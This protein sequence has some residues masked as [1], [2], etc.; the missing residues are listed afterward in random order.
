[1]RAIGNRADSRT[2]VLALLLTVIMVFSVIA[3]APGMVVAESDEHNLLEDG[4]DEADEIYVD[5]DGNAVLIYSDEDADDDDLDEVELG[6]HVAEGIMY[7]FAADSHDVD[8]ADEFENVEMHASALLRGDIFEA[9]GSL[10]LDQPDE[11]GELDVD[12]HGEVSDETNELSAEAYA[13]F[14]D[15]TGTSAAIGQVQ[16]SGDVTIA[17]DSFAMQADGTFASG[18][19]PSADT[20][21]IDVSIEESDGTYS[22]EVTQ[23]EYLSWFEAEQ[24]ETEQA[25]RDTL[26]QEF[27]MIAQE[28]GGE[29]H[30]TIDHYHFEERSDRYWLELEYSVEMSG[31]DDGLA[32]LIAEGLMQDPDIDVDE[33]QAIAIGEAVTEI[34]IDRFDIAFVDDGATVEFDIDVQIDGFDELVFAA[35][36]VFEDEFDE[37]D[38]EFE[39]VEDV[40]EMY[41]A[42]AAADMRTHITWDVSIEAGDDGIGEPL[43]A[44]STNDP[45]IVVDAEFGYEVEN[46]Q[47]YVAELNDRG[48]D[49]AEYNFA[50]TFEMYDVDDQIH[51]EGAITVEQEDLVDAAMDSLTTAMSEEADDPAAAEFVD[52]LEQTNLEVAKIDLALDDEEITIE[53]GAQVDD[54]EEFFRNADVVPDEFVMDEPGGDLYVHLTNV[55]EE[56]DAFDADDLESYAFVGEDTEIHA[57]GEWDEEFPEFDVQSAADYLDVE[58]SEGGDDETSPD[59]DTIPGFGPIAALIAV[60]GALVARTYGR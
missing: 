44:Q 51:A 5:E 31:V 3:A 41:E 34:H 16:T 14:V 58:L 42:Q 32:Q 37:L 48:I 46:W 21:R 1:M 26:T 7:M 6:A 17:H 47:A 43:A 60:L 54:L 53:A 19:Q 56:P 2:R 59:D 28:L 45:T 27:E 18:A 49:T 33:D 36:E 40:P 22:A 55:V 13:E 24:Y 8:E 10:S 11:I 39:D 29:A 25:A 30:V 57:P 4:L 50:F 38:E 15:E 23:H 20:E 9:D 35:L 12:I 52:I